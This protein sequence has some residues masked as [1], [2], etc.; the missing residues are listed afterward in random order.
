MKYFNESVTGIEIKQQPQLWSETVNIIEDNKLKIETFLRK[1][2]PKTT[3]VIF[4]GAGT[5]EFVGNSTAGYINKNSKFKVESIPTTDIVSNPTH[6]LDKDETT[7]LVSCA[8]S[9]NSPESIGAVNLANNLVTDIHHIFLTCSK[10]GELAKRSQGSP[11]ELLILMPEKSND[12]GFAMTGSFTCMS[13][14]GIL[15]FNLSKLN[16]IKENITLISQ[17]VQDSFENIFKLTDELKKIETKRIVCLGDGTLKGLAQE[18]SLK[19]LELSS[20]YTSTNFDSS[21][22]FRH[23]PKSIITDETLIIIFMSNN[24]YTRRYQ[25]DLLKEFKND[26]GGKTVVAIDND[27]DSNVKDNSNFYFSFNDL[28]M[29]QLN[30]VFSNFG[31][32]Y[33]AQMYAFLKS[34]NLG[35]NPDNP[36]P[37][38]EVNRVVQGVTLYDFNEAEEIA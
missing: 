36:C 9:G 1:F 18:A 14:A 5:S 12:K 20:G 16:K 28:K 17:K 30:D 3:R 29:S 37:S 22:G 19:I 2:N 32:I 27:F 25:L 6:Y 13:L 11:N 8:R 33:I 38:G 35:I 24:T 4:T 23:G 21:L 15:V 34:I 10:D 26:G 31:Y 7:I